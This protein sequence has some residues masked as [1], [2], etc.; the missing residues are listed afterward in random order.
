MILLDVMADSDQNVQSVVESPNVDQASVTREGGEGALAE[1]NEETVSE[2]TVTEKLLDNATEN[3]DDNNIRDE[4]GSLLT[5]P[6]GE[7]DEGEQISEKSPI[8]TEVTTDASSSSS[9]SFYS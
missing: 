2:V 4:E 3:N 5:L 8:Q 6:R 7:P 1:R 9:V